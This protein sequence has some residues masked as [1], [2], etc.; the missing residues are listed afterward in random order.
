MSTNTTTNTFVANNENEAEALVE[1]FKNCGVS[2]SR[3]G[4]SVKAIGEPKY[5]EHLFN[6]YI[7]NALV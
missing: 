3:K 5:V 7:I 6:I 1:F 4:L 2:A